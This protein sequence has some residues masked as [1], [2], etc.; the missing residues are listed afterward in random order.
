M[1][2]ITSS[3]ASP[4]PSAV[5]T[6]SDK[7]RSRLHTVVQGASG[8]SAPVYVSQFEVEKPIPTQ[9]TYQLN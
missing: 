1:P 5:V 3:T 6:L 8:S 9:V 2:T 4:T 7:D